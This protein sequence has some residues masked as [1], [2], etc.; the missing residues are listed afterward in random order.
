MG[1]ARRSFDHQQE[2]NLKYNCS[3][4][5][6]FFHKIFCLKLK[7]DNFLNFI[8]SKINSPTVCYAPYCDILDFFIKSCF[9]SVVYNEIYVLSNFR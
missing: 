2:A 6:N 1:S 9:A 4:P 8:S 7:L 5:Q 3:S